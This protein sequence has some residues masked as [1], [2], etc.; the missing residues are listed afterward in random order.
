MNNV[1]FAKHIK[2]EG[3]GDCGDIK[4]PQPLIINKDV[5]SATGS[6]S[7]TSNM[8]SS[9]YNPWNA[10]QLIVFYLKEDKL[11]LIFKQTSNITL[12]TWPPQT[13]SPRIYKE[14][15]KAQG[16]KIVLVE[17][18]EGEFIAASEESYTFDK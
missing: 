18:I 8:I 16:D 7:G 1:S 17:T 11:E 3:S 2:I 10:P 6:L 12:T 5:I 4:N 9:S 14:V 15:Y 13:P